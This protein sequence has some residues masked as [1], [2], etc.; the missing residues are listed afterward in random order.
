MAGR[1]ASDVDPNAEIV[2]VVAYTSSGRGWLNYGAVCEISRSVIRALADN[3]EQTCQ[4][5]LRASVANVEGNCC[6]VNGTRRRLHYNCLRVE[7][8]S[9]P[10]RSPDRFSDWSESVTDR[11]EGYIKLIYRCRGMGAED[12]EPPFHFHVQFLLQLT[13]GRQRE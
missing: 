4:T 9:D 6:G 3:P 8:F 1:L 7:Y 11:L 10:A 12:G 13:D 2:L 5:I